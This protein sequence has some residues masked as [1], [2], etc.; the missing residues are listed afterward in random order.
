MKKFTGAT[1]ADELRWEAEEQQRRDTIA[2]KLVGS[3]I[4][5]ADFNPEYLDLL[6]QSR[7]KE[8]TDA[9]KACAAIVTLIAMAQMRDSDVPVSEGE[10]A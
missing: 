1:S 3:V 10:Q 9:E 5:S 7:K 8:A 2:A 6:A 4:S